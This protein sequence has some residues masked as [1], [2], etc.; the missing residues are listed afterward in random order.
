MVYIT[1][2][3][4]YAETA[5]SAEWIKQRETFIKLNGCFTFIVVE[6]YLKIVQSD[7]YL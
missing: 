4:K 7:F 2:E 3:G 1:S 5:S 6:T